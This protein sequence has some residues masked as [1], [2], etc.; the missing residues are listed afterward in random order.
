MFIRRVVFARR[1]PKYQGVG[2]AL[3]NIDGILEGCDF[4]RVTDLLYIYPINNI[5]LFISRVFGS[6]IREGMGKKP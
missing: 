1:L 5:E 4:L 6:E 2:E 3:E